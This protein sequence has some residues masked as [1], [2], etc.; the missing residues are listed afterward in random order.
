MYDISRLILTLIFSVVHNRYYRQNDKDNSGFLAKNNKLP[1]VTNLYFSF[2][3]AD[4][5]FINEKLLTISWIDILN[6]YD[7][8]IML[9]L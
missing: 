7:V 8:K 3:N 6:V 9:D 4:F 1:Y 2:Y 5:D